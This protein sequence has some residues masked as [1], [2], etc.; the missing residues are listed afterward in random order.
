MLAVASL[1]TASFATA[2]P[3]TA[4]PT[5]AGDLW[6]R[7]RLSGDWFGFR[8]EL[9]KKGLRALLAGCGK[10][11]P[12]QSQIANPAFV[13]VLTRTMTVN[14]DRKNMETSR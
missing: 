3:V 2:Q 10:A 8:D 6:S 13:G 5:Y 7:P 4:P 9:A 11:N 12:R 1:V 14:P